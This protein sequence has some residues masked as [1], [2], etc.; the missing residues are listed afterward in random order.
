MGTAAWAVRA[1][2]SRTSAFAPRLLRAPGAVTMGAM[3]ALELSPNALAVLRHR[4]LRKDPSGQVVE[5]PEELF[6]R[7]AAAVALAEERFVPRERGR[8]EATFFEA[9]AGR[10]FLPN[11]PT[12]MNA[13]TAIGQLA[14]CFVL[15]VPDSIPGIFGA[16]T[17]MALIHQTGGGTGFS[18]SRLRPAGDVVAE[19][20]GVASGPV[21]FMRVFDVATDVIKQ[22]GRRRGA[23]M[24][25]LAVEHPDIVAF[26][27][28]KDDRAAMTNFNLSVAVSDAFMEAVEAGRPW[29]LVNPRTGEVVRS[30]DARELWEIICQA[31]W[32]NGDPGL[33][34]ID[35]VNRHNPTP[36]LGRIEATNPCGEQPLL[37]YESC[38]LGS[39]N[40]ARL[41]EG[42]VFDWG[43]LDELVRLGVR[44]LDDVIEVNRFPLP[45]IAEMTKANRKVGLG[46]MGF[47]EALVELGIPY[48]SEEALRFA[49]QVM[50]RIAG[51]ARDASAELARERGPFPNYERSI[52]K[53]RGMPPL[54]NA[55]VTTI[56]PTGTISIIANT[57]SGIEPLF[58]L[59]FHRTVLDGQDLPEVNRLFVRALEKEGLPV[60]AVLEHVSA[61]G[62]V[63]GCEMVPERVRRL[64]PVALDLEPTWHVRMQA[65]FQRHTDNAVSKTV[66]L[67][68][69]APVEAVREAFRLAYEL[70]C[71]GITVFRYG[72]RGEQVLELGRVPSFVAGERAVAHAEFAGEC[73]IC[74]T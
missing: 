61:T 70:G 4:Y 28:V 50:E 23:N 8:W 37:P 1:V 18:F 58:A 57:S 7:V 41:A 55:T 49:D 14:A 68:Q 11:S 52:W 13:G 53:Q 65:V 19:T 15:P 22:G 62:S 21:S 67:R 38:N 6:R 3:T 31:A 48:D 16:V 73:R 10:W 51:V 47:A 44:F 36:D 29:P 63:R 39:I 56:A 2:E 27:T 69:D 12:L 24:G 54:R 33:L 46:V 43:R 64:F 30:V 40:L 9:M 71:K 35:Q 45:A 66:N 42:G 34:F 72:C 60:D 20:G 25:V 5:T 32:R 17:E 59:A 26:V 74:S